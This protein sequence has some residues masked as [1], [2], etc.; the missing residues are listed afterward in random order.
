MTKVLLVID[1]V[2]GFIEQRVGETVCSLFLPGAEGIIPNINREINALTNDDVL[3]FACDTHE[4]NDEEF[5]KWSPHCIKGSGQEEIV[6]GIVAPSGPTLK[7]ISKTRFSAFF[8][9]LLESKLFPYKVDEIIITGV[10]TD[11]C[12]FATALDARYRD[13][14]VT[15]PKD[16]VF[17]LDPKTGEFMLQWLDRMA[18]VTVR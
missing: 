16:C 10:C 3:I 11:I 9:T 17:P 7:K 6:S 15:I 2:R 8:N 18:G 4:E 13:Y 14:K 12:V 5:K 1:M